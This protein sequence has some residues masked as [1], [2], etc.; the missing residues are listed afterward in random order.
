MRQA[1]P[2]HDS[3]SI[4]PAEPQSE[5]ARRL[6]AGASVQ[7]MMRRGEIGGQALGLLQM[8][9]AGV[10]AES[11]PRAYGRGSERTP[12]GAN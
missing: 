8:M 4:P 2:H 6:A 1:H 3:P 10:Q 7:D 5:L 11:R 12:L 9:A